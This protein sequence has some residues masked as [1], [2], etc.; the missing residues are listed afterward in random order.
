MVVICGGS[1]LSSSCD[2]LDSAIEANVM[3]SAGGMTCVVIGGAAISVL[4][5]ADKVEV[6]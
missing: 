1:D 3:G 2:S 5:A 4:D 6:G